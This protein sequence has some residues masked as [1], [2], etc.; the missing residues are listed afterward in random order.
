MRSTATG[1]T[2]VLRWFPAWDSVNFLLVVS[3]MLL[4]IVRLQLA[5][6]DR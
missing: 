2:E 6:G 5:D 3:G 1:D 4:L